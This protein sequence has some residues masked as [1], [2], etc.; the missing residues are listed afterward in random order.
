MPSGEGASVHLLIYV[1]QAKIRRFLIVV[2]I[3]PVHEL[4]TEKQPTNKKTK[5]KQ[6]TYKV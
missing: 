4:V 1:L 5:I 3:N 2:R 6:P